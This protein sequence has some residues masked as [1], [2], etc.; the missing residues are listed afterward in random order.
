MIKKV[1]NEKFFEN[2]NIYPSRKGHVKG[3]GYKTL[4][5]LIS[6]L[7]RIDANC[8]KYN[9]KTTIMIDFPIQSKRENVYKFTSSKIKL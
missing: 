7:K 5:G 4:K 1:D 6:E 3:I 8:K 2:I 9:F